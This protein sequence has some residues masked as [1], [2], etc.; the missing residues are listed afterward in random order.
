MNISKIHVYITC[1][2]LSPKL[3]S[4]IFAAIVAYALGYNPLYGMAAFV[5]LW[6]TLLFVEV[7]RLWIG[8]DRDKKTVLGKYPDAHLREHD[9]EG[10][11][12]V[13][14]GQDFV[15]GGSEFQAWKFAAQKIKEQ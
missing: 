6:V 11:I 9:F 8:N 3:Y 13:A 5:L 10:F 4:A 15:Y 12:L 1:W 7:A 14:D 2:L